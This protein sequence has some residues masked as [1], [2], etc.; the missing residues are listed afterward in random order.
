MDQGDEMT[1]RWCVLCGSEYV[2]GVLECAD[3]LVPLVDDQPVAAE[4]VGD[5]DEAQ[6]AYELD[7]L[8]ATDRFDLDRRLADAGIVHAWDGESLIVREADEKAVDRLVDE[9]ADAAGLGEDQ[10]VV[11]YELGDWSEEKRDELSSVLEAAEI[12]FEWED[13]TNDL[14]VNS[15]DADRVEAIIDDLEY[16]DQLPIGGDDE[17]GLFGDGRGEGA[18]ADAGR[19][20]SGSAGS[21]EGA[22]VVDDGL[23]AQEAMSE[24]FVASDRLMHDPEDHEG[25]L[26]AVD[27]AR[28][29]EALS[30]PFGF[31]PA[32]WHDLVGQ[33]KALRRAL[34][35]DADDQEIMDRATTLRT[36][37]RQY[38]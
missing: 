16:P 17:D 26:A 19:A 3:C 15:D 34:E 32:V 37:L 36:L 25:V 14:V 6:L 33:A 29:A 4:Q 10:G 23:A 7:E 22:G 11:G 24:L 18:G 21:G 8:A 20:G 38:V 27:A 12:S 30:L 31:T 9:V 13:E 28:W 5:E 2:A 1:S 35:G